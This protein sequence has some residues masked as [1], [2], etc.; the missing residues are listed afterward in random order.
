[1]CF[2]VSIPPAP[3]INPCTMKCFDGG[4]KFIVGFSF[5]LLYSKLMISTF[6]FLVINLPVWKWTL[7][8]QMW[9]VGDGK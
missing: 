6:L 2:Y 3:Q 4:E 1:M 7:A 9:H 8:G 5:V